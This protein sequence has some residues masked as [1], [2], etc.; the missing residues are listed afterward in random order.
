MRL[1]FKFLLFC[2]LLL[3]IN[4]INA[5]TVNQYIYTTVLHQY[6][7]LAKQHKINSQYV[8]LIDF[9]LS[10]T[11]KRL[12]VIDTR[13]NKIILNLKV[14]HGIGSGAGEYAT[15]FS[16]KVNSHASSLGFYITDSIHYGHN[17]RSLRVR[18]IDNTNSNAYI[19]IILFHPA[20]YISENSNKIGHSWGCFAV[21]SKYSNILINLIKNHSLVYVYK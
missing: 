7:I 14:T 10:D 4:N 2:V 17:G 21:D 16:N 8:T 12:Y 20:P 19:R 9:S 11:A 3:I 1:V 6:N 5:N 18:G 15:S 13:T